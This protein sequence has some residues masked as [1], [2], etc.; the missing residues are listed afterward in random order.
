MTD[1][2]P[3]L[4][5]LLI[6]IAFGLSLAHVLELP[7]KLR[8]DRETYCKVQEIYYP[9]FT[10]GGMVGEAGGLLA[11]LA[12]LIATPAESERFWWMADA[13]ALLAAA[14]AVYWLVTHPVNAFW[15]KG[16]ELAVPSR[17][18][19]AAFSGVP[20]GEE[21]WESL[22]DTWEYSHLVR[23]VLF[24]ASLVLMTVALGK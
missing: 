13:F 4:A 23:A 5:L 11:A 2:L 19:F 3:S 24:G 6:A 18:F 22:R 15:L 20:P 21:R 1:I 16:T 7:G 17:A 12:A 14:H 9:G 8:L 10:L